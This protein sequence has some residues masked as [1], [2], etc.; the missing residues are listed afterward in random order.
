MKMKKKF[1]SLISIVTVVILSQ[2]CASQKQ[3]LRAEAPHP[4]T[5]KAEAKPTS[6]V[7]TEVPGEYEITVGDNL[8]KQI[9]GIKVKDI[10][11]KTKDLSTLV[12][13]KNT[14]LILVKPGCVFCESLLAVM[15]T[16]NPTIKPQVFFILDEAHATEKEFKEK[17]NSHSK[18]RATWI[19]D[20]ENKFHD[21]LAMSSF[22]RLLYIDSKQTVIHN[23]VGLVLPE[24]PEQKEA[25]KKEA[26][27]IVLQKLSQTTVAWMQSLQ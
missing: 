15:D 18:I 5:I 11:M 9:A 4:S 20:Y 23:Q 8:T 10:K 14:L 13:N 12:S 24:D 25:L 7:T 19:Y 16:L 22:P 27:P 6:G 21:K 2:A 26:F 17:Y 1:L 3:D